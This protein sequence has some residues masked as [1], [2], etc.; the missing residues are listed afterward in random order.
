[1]SCLLQWEIRQ[2]HEKVQELINNI[3]EITPRVAIS[4]APAGGLSASISADTFGFHL[5]TGVAIDFLHSSAIFWIAP[6]GQKCNS[7]SH[8]PRK[9]AKKHVSVLSCPCWWPS[10][11][12]LA[13]TVMTK[14]TSTRHIMSIMVATYALI[15]RA[16]IYSQEKPCL[17]SPQHIS[18]NY[19]QMT[20]D[21]VRSYRVIV[22]ISVFLSA[23]YS[24]TGWYLVMVNM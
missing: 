19:S 12:T 17:S 6:S 5:C 16:C 23:K 2:I 15:S 4:S 9:L 22:V 14:W 7:K 3:R 21:H 18:R 10:T 1:M 20:I 13:D 24:V 11:S 8:M